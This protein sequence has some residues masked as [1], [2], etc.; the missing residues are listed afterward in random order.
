LKKWISLFLVLLCT[1][2]ACS[3]SG[4]GDRFLDIRAEYL[5]KEFDFT[6]DL[7]VDYDDKRY[8][9]TVSYVGDDRKGSVK[10]LSPEVLEGISAE[11]HEDGTVTLLY[12]DVM[13][14]TGEVYGGGCS[15]A[16]VLPL[17]AKSI[18]SGYVA[19]AYRETID[20]E[21]YLVAEMDE[22]AAGS[23]E[24]IIFAVWFRLADYGL[25]KAEI[26]VDGCTVMEIRFH[27]SK[28]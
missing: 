15:P 26:R 23:E 21:E 1:F 17:L 8:D 13:L 24:Q 7:S 6:A 18:R 3:G 28:G 9:F 11:I 22:T 16:E 25:Y 19:N 10:I 5:G 14:D 20:D 4:E 27:E 12:G 2:S